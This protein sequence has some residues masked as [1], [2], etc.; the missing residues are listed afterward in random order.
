MQLGGTP[1]QLFDQ[2]RDGVADVVWTLPGSTAGRFPSIEVFELPFIAAQRGRVNAQAVHEFMTMHMAN[3]V[4]EVKLLSAFAHDR[5]L[6]HTNKEITK[7]ED[8][9]GLKLRAASRMIGEAMRALGVTPVGMP[10]PQVPESLAQK[11]IDGVAIPW[12]VVPTVKV[13]ELTRFHLD[14]PGRPAF[15]TATFFLAMNKAKYESMPADLRDVID[16]ESGMK[17]AALAGQMWDDTA[18]KGREL[19]AKRSGNKLSDLSLEEKARWMKACEPVIAKW[20]DEMK[21]RNIDGGKLVEAAR[22]LIAK[23]DV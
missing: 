19:V 12:E 16:A 4:R 11:V 3:E 20:I 23:Y 14:I 17:H 1:P 18:V 15:Y 8:L 5:G 9:Q 6:L 7:M 2:A 21:G 13:H 10:I 22:A